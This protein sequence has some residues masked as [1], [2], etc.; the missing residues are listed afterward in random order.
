MFGGDFPSTIA[1]GDFPAAVDA[2]T[3]FY[4]S[5][6]LGS[7]LGLMLMNAIPS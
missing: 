5:H 7:K 3:T 4:T 1:N 2:K 6:R